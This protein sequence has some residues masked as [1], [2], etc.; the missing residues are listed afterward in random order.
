MTTNERIAEWAGWIQVE[1]EDD[2]GN[3]Y[4]EWRNPVNDCNKELPA[5]NTNITLWHGEDGLSAEITNKKLERLFA[6]E[7]L[8]MAP[9]GGFIDCVLIGLLAT[10]A[11]LAAALVKVIEETT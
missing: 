2:D 5:F 1:C 4:L 7:L 3:P 10:P 8:W 11:Q 6:D 9:D